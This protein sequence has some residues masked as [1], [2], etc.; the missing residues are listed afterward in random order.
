MTIKTKLISAFIL[1]GIVP[2]MIVG[3]VMWYATDK[4]GYE[5]G[6]NYENIAIE[7]IEMVERNLAERY[8]DVQAFALNEIIHDKKYWYQQDEDSNHIVLAMNRY[9]KTYGIYNLMILVD[10]EGKVIA[11]NDKDTS[12][13]EIDTHFIYDM[14]FADSQ[15]FKKAIKGDFLKSDKLTG[16]V[17]EDVHIDPLVKKVFGS[18]GLTL[19]YSTPVKDS[20]DQIVGVWK[21]YTNWYVVEEIIVNSYKNLADHDMHSAELTLLDKSGVILVD[22]DPLGNGKEINHDMEKVILKLNLAEKG[23]QAAQLAVKGENGHNESVHARKQINQVSGYAHSKGAKGYPGLGW[24]L[25]VRV[26]A[27]EALAQIHSI[28]WLLIGVFAGT[29]LAVSILAFFVTMSITRPIHKLTL[30]MQDIAEGEGDLTVKVD[31]SG[32]DELSALGHWF[33]IFIEKIRDVVNQV[34]SATQEVASAAAE[35][36]SSADEMANGLSQQ[37]QQTTQVSAAIEEMNA[38]VSEVA[39]KSSDAAKTSRES[40]ENA[41][42]GGE[43]V[44]RTVTS[45]REI[46][47]LV[48]ESA[49]EI[50]ELGKRSEQIGQII[51]VINDIADQTN[52]LALNAAIEAARAGEH[53][54]GF[55]VVADEVRKLAERTTQ[56]TKEVSDSIVAIQSQTNQAVQRMNTGTQRVTEGVS[57]AEQAGDALNLIVNGAGKVVTLIESIAAASTE[58]SQAAG[59]IARNVES[60]STVTRQTNEGATQ[61]AAAASQLSG[62]AEELQRLVNRFKTQ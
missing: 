34:N 12:G 25:L 15:W 59:D 23:V 14:N 47:T 4:M 8:G 38:T 56:A 18:E 1:C 46:A 16:T 40:G 13:K 20:Q 2:L 27:R 21:N 45:I 57:M 41:A 26:D 54:R 17:V 55:A 24:S 36:A 50:D 19:G 44:Q 3:S 52:L 31:E 53:G 39:Y 58:Q 42:N 11:V 5:V 60:I 10:L 62:K 6:T 33:N 9:T 51:D 49:S 30:R 43:I 7:T 32:K 61:S 22:C 29:I 35:I 28:R 37:T 48:N